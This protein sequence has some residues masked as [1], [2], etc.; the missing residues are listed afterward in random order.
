MSTSPESMRK[1]VCYGYN[2]FQPKTL[3][4]NPHVIKLWQRK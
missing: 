1:I 4:K 3:I 2:K